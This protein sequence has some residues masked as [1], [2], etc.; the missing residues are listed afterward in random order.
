MQELSKAAGK[1]AER[2]LQR[3]M[4]ILA[5]NYGQPTGSL[6][7]GLAR[8]PYTVT[9]GS[10]QIDVTIVYPRTIRFIDLRRIKKGGELKHSYVPIYNRITSSYMYGRGYSLANLVNIICWEHIQSSLE[11]V[12]TTINSTKL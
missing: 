11:D 8:M 3:Q 2:L 7:A 10:D 12:T 1:F 4:K 5:E 6:Y 9:V